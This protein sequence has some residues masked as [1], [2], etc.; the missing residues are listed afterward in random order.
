LLALASG[1]WSGHYL[2]QQGVG[3]LQLLRA[4]RRVADVLGDPTVDADTRRRLWLAMSARAF[5]IQVLGLRDG[6]AFTRYLELGGRPLAWNVTAAQ[7]DRLQL[8][9]N[10]FPLVG[11]IPYLGFFHEADA[12]AEEARLQRL[13]LDTYVRPVA[14]Y[15]TLGWTADSIYSSMLRGSEARIVEV[16]LHEMLH[17]T[18]FLRGRADWNESLAT[19][20]GLRGA[21]AFFAL[22]GGAG[23]ARQI[24]EEAD[25][26]ERDER[27]FSAFLQ[28]VLAELDALYRSALTRDEKLR[29]REQ[30]FARARDLYVRRFPP[31]PGHS[32]GA[33]AEQPLN[34]AVLLSY[35]VYHRATPEHR[36]LFAR[37]GG[38][39]GAFIALYKYAVENTDDPIEYLKRR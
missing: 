16:V 37:V 3:Q 15:S 19:F 6:D 27:D 1:C 21:A 11:A 13:G 36:R 4:R 30:M 32:R 20:V 31:R 9:L 17:G 25:E 7:K 26:R 39:L 29:R 2:A 18:L 35:G 10:H 14:G 38:D 8:H 5:G 22:R 33:F 23:T 24:L 34:N 28:P 12:R